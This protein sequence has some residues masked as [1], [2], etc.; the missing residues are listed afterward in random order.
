MNHKNCRAVLTAAFMV[1]LASALAPAQQPPKAELPPIAPNA[2]RLDQTLGGLD[3]PGF[4]LAYDESS[5][6][7][8]A[9]CEGRSIHY[10]DKAVSQGIR[11]GSATPNVLK[12]HAGPL[13]ALAW[14]GGAILA[15]AAA[16]KKL[17]FWHM[18]DGQVVKSLTTENVVRAL[19]MSPDGKTL[20]S[21]G[22]DAAIQVWD[23]SA[24]KA[25]A[26]LSGSSDWILC[27]AFSNDGQR[28]ASG[29]YDG[30]VRLWE[31]ASSKK[32]LD[33]PATPPPPRVGFLFYSIAG[34][35]TADIDPLQRSSSGSGP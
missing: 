17:I 24:A 4:T 34:S 6:M 21:A 25:G 22:E 13:T 7:L 14:S 20:V 33:V 9:A 31:V 19:A 32:I 10:W 12:E 27:L 23:V 8:A 29:G 3:G 5:G 18:P 11:G 28:L 30:T 2:A 1:L 26:K 35:T 15:S 16:D